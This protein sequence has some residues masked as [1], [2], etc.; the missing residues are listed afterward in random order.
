[1][2]GTKGVCRLCGCTGQLSRPI[3]VLCDHGRQPYIPAMDADVRLVTSVQ[4]KLAQGETAFNRESFISSS[5]FASGVAGTVPQTFYQHVTDQR[6]N[7]RN[8]EAFPRKDV[9]QIPGQ[10][11]VA[12]IGGALHLAHQKV[13]IEEKNDE[14]DLDDGSPGVALH[15]VVALRRPWAEAKTLSSRKSRLAYFARSRAVRSEL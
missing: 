11:F 3:I 5:L 4:I 9:V 1:M 14:A 2:S 7:N 15:V 13:G 8:E 10:A 6:G 12:P